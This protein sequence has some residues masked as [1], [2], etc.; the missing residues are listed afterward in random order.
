[1]LITIDN[2]KAKIQAL[3]SQIQMMRTII[4]EQQ[5]DLDAAE[6]GH[7]SPV[8]FGLSSPALLEGHSGQRYTA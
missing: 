5:L 7:A 3:E 1:M 8:L 6:A 2:M 4:I